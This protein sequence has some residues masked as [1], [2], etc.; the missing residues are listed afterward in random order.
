VNFASP[1]PRAAPV[2]IGRNQVPRSYTSSP[3]TAD[4]D[5]PSSSLEFNPPI[6]LLLELMDIDDPSPTF[7]YVEFENE[8][9]KFN[10]RG[11]LDVHRLPTMLLATFGELKYYGASHL[12]AYVNERL[13]PLIKPGRKVDKTE[14]EVGSGSVVADTQEG[15]SGSVVADTQEVEGIC[16]LEYLDACSDMAVEDGGHT[17]GLWKGKGRL[18]KEESR[19]VIMVWPSDEEDEATLPPIEVL[20]DD[21]GTTSESSESFVSAV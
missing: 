1:I 11:I 19:E 2:E 16:K 13:M 9:R 20:H 17:T 5:V 12:Q 15:G 3:D 7:K 6:R 10:V 4:P 18:L 21:A 14:Q 8:L